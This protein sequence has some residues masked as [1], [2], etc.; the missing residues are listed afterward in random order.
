MT[1]AIAII[2]SMR[3]IGTHL[4]IAGLLGLAL[5][6]SS[7]DAPGDDARGIRCSLEAIPPWQDCAMGG[8]AE[9]RAYLDVEPHA[10]QVL[11]ISWLVC[12]RGQSLVVDSRFTVGRMSMADKPAR[13]EGDFSSGA[14]SQ[15]C[16][17]Q[18]RLTEL[19]VG[20]MR[21]QGLVGVGRA[22][23]MWVVSL[24]VN[25]KLLPRLREL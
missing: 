18:D 24:W 21:W 5:G 25:S 15:A 10:G 1:L 20:R 3:F 14:Q 9:M 7:S 12:R 11:S 2:N 8:E 4:G 22:D 19:H 13:R 6:S 16:S 17:T 23:V